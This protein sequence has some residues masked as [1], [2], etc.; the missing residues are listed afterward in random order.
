[1]EKGFHGGR[2]V[3]LSGFVLHVNTRNVWQRAAVDG[4]HV[5]SCP[6]HAGVVVVGR[7]NLDRSKGQ[8]TRAIIC[9]IGPSTRTVSRD[10]AMQESVVKHRRET[11]QRGQCV[12][13]IVSVEM[14]LIPIFHISCLNCQAIYVF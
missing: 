6:R 1:M 4:A 13:T 10:I 7:I 14:G 5:G 3:C 9:S 12:T 2:I 11:D 8:L